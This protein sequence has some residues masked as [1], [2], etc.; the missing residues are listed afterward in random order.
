MRTLFTIG[1]SN[2][3][4]EEFLELL[5]IHGIELIVDVRKMPRSRTN[6]QFNGPELADSLSTRGIAYTHLESLSGFRRG[7]KA[8]TTNAWEN[9]SFQAYAAYMETPEFA[10]GI[11]ALMEMSRQKS[12]AVM[13]SEAVWWRCHRRMI[14]DALLAR[15]CDVRHILSRSPASGHELTKFAKLVDGHVTY[16][17]VPGSS[18]PTDRKKP[19]RGAPRKH[20]SQPFADLS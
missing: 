15:D 7:A 8:V 14:A 17:E 11:G 19:T 5:Q 16:P 4:I 2:R 1:H 6:P 13:C 10:A 9:K 18:P 12:V 20:Q 3:E